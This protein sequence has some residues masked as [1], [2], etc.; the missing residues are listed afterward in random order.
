MKK[1]IPILLTAVLFSALFLQTLPAEAVS[2]SAAEVKKPVLTITTKITDAGEPIHMKWNVPN[3]EYVILKKQSKSGSFTAVHGHSR[4]SGKMPDRVMIEE[5]AGVYHYLLSAKI[6][7]QFVQSEPVQVIVRQGVSLLKAKGMDKIWKLSAVICPTVKTSN[8]HKSFTKAEINHIRNL[9]SLL[10]GTLF[11]LSDG[12]MCAVVT[13]VVVLDQPV[14]SVSGDSGDLV[15]GKDFP[16]EGCV[17]ADTTALLVY[18]PL[19][20]HPAN[21][22]LGLGGYTHTWK[23]HTFFMAEFSS[24]FANPAKGNW[25]KDGVRYEL[26]TCALVH[27]LLHA[28]ELNSSNN[29]WSG[30]QEVHGAGP[31]GYTD[32]YAF[33]D[34]YADLMRDTLKNGK[35][36]FH[37]AS[38]YVPQGGAGRNRAGQ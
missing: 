6:N 34:W 15:P 37:A 26:G 18:A 36:G 23:G 27:E 28:V 10:P 31:N 7:G 22:W 1:I 13:D 11:N 9:L 16:L 14:T 32:R 35:S 20:N 17:S 8:F 25:E 29:G 5:A 2:F 4:L 24:A 19:V 30:F 38:F 33:M 3:A 12:R 21:Y